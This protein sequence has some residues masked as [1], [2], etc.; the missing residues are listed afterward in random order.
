MDSTAA[1]GQVRSVCVF[2]KEE[3]ISVEILGYP[4]N[5]PLKRDPNPKGGEE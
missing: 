5:Y 3:I 4:G 2:P 1:T